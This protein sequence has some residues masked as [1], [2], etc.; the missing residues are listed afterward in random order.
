MEG[1]EIKYN[2]LPVRLQCSVKKE[3]VI[4]KLSDKIKDVEKKE[5]NKA[6]KILGDDMEGKKK[7]AAFLGIS[8]AS[9]HNKLK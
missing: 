1:N 8:L 4:Q 6:L 2:H 5:I 7:A 3:N 9:L